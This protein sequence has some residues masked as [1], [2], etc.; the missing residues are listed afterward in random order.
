MS[1]EINKMLRI[2][3]EIIENEDIINKI[4]KTCDEIQIEFFEL[5]SKKDSEL[6]PLY[7]M[8]Y[9]YLNSKYPPVMRYHN[10]YE[11]LRTY[12]LLKQ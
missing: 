5:L 3:K 9:E 6:I 11:I 2:C 10:A 7:K 12:L 1:K 8:R 4:F